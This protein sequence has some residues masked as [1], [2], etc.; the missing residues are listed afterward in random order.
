MRTL[1]I[2]VV[3]LCLMP[4]SA[5]AQI[6][7]GSSEEKVYQQIAAETSGDAKLK[8]ISDFE[9]EF[10]HSKVLPNVFLIAVDLYREKGDTDRV[11]EYAEKVMT[12]DERNLTAMMVLS[13]NYAI[14]RK[15][16]DRS[17]ELAQKA[18][19]QL[20]K[21]RTEPI[22]AQYTEAQWKEYLDSTEA[23]ARSILAYAKGMTPKSQEQ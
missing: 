7:A 15:H 21:M 22:P 19:D 5:H 2:P 13:R 16:L 10:P 6:V 11:I 3:L 23:A 8:D 1:L 4:Q 20:L 12:L 18:V 14:Q 17:A 9:R